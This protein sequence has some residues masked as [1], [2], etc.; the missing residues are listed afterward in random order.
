MLAF[1]QSVLNDN[2]L[3]EDQPKADPA[4]DRYI[5]VFKEEATAQ[6]GE[7]NLKLAN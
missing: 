5:V 1:L 6:D 7:L 3:V 2:A 4:D